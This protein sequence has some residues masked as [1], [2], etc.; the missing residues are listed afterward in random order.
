M[1]GKTTDAK[2]KVAEKVEP[3]V[4]EIAER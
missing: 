1:K 3:S 2:E 4:E